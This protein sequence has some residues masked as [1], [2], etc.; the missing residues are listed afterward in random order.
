MLSDKFKQEI[1]EDGLNKERMLDFR[2]SNNINTY[3]SLDDYLNFLRGIQ[4]IFGNFLV[5]DKI[6]KT[7]N[8]KL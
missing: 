2:Q 3:L 7:E 1:L 8:N 5:S 6:T 4:K